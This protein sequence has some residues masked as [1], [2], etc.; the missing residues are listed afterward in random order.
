VHFAKN[1][2]HFNLLVEGKMDSVSFE[3]AK[4]LVAAHAV[5]NAVIRCVDGRK[6]AI[7]LRVNHDFILKSERQNPRRFG[8]IETA[9]GEI[10]KMG[11]QRADIDFEKWQPEQQAL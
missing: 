5:T 11:F 6:W 7:V 4:H 9:L 1:A 2:Y 10:K 8:T 3:S